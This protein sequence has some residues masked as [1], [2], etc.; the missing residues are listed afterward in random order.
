MAPYSGLSIMSV[1]T[2]YKDIM[3]FHSD[4]AWVRTVAVWSNLPSLSLCSYLS[5]PTCVGVFLCVS[6]DSFLTVKPTILEAELT[7]VDVQ[8]HMSGKQHQLTCTVFGSPLPTVTWH[9]QPCHSDVTLKEWVTISLCCNLQNVLTWICAFML[10]LF[11]E[12][13]N[14]TFNYPERESV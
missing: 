4:L 7:S 2:H 10:W 12:I 8:P 9:W 11:P 1:A 5:F 13:L 3:R 14:Q 6:A